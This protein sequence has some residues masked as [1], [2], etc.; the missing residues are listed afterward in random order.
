MAHLHNFHKNQNPSFFSSIGQK[1]KVGAEI[2]TGLKTI[3]DVGKTIYS[4]VGPA[5]ALAAFV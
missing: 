1:N 3:F 5:V 2:A 4:A